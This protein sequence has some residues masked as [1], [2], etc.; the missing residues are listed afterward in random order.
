M[1]RVRATVPNGMQELIYVNT[2]KLNL[3]SNGLKANLNLERIP[4]YVI[5][6][7]LNAS[8]KQGVSGAVAQHLVGAKLALRFPD[9]EIDNHSHAT[10]AKQ[11]G[12]KGDFEVNDTIFHVAVLPGEAVVEK[13]RRNV[14]RGFSTV[15]LVPQSEIKAAQ[16]FVSRSDTAQR[17]WVMSIEEFVGQNIAEI[18]EFKKNGFRDNLKCLLETYNQRVAAAETRRDFLV[19]I[20]ENF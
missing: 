10:Q 13:C 5:S 8:R 1:A 19:N 14:R 6:K 7:I 9:L 20:P 16:V 15:L 2:V 3:G 18:G 17:I 11:L 4:P 12:R